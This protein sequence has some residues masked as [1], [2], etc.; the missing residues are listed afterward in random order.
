[1]R[2]SSAKATARLLKSLG[3]DPPHRFDN[4]EDVYLAAPWSRPSPLARDTF[5][6]VRGD[7]W[8]LSATRR[9]FKDL[10]ERHITDD[11][12]DDPRGYRLAAV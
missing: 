5:E 1:M 7:G 2:Q 11:S 8:R 9:T 10:V 3:S 12:A 6:V 4:A